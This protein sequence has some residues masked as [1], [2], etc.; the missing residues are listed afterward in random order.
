MG[1]AGA[2]EC[3]PRG[4]Q[5]VFFCEKNRAGAATGFAHPRA[6]LSQLWIR[7]HDVALEGPV[8]ALVV[9]TVI[10]RYPES[11]KIV[12]ATELGPGHSD[13]HTS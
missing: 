11:V 13:C 2:T 9:A 12:R 10:E 1:A 4:V 6:Q 5:P 8:G 3:R 7:I